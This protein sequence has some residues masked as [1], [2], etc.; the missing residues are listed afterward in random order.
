M[1]SQTHTHTYTQTD[2]IRDN[3]GLIKTILNHD[4][5]SEHSVSWL[6][7]TAVLK[8]LVRLHG[9]N[10]QHQRTKQKNKNKTKKLDQ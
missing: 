4:Y 2:I 10:W 1:L 7:T 6:M 5:S 9:F 3:W 8:H